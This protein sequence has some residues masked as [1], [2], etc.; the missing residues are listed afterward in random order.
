M[1]SLFRGTFCHGFFQSGE[2]L[3]QAALS[4][5]Y[6]QVAARPFQH[7]AHHIGIPPQAP[8]DRIREVYGHEKSV[9]VVH[10]FQQVFA[11]RKIVPAQR[12]ENKPPQLANRRDAELLISR[13][14]SSV[15]SEALAGSTAH[16]DAARMLAS[17]KEFRC[18]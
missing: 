10:K 4:Q 11:S 17:S 12:I 13:R 15:L 16:G 7:P 14:G 8:R 6:C 18:R 2:L 9:N 3:L 5:R 1:T